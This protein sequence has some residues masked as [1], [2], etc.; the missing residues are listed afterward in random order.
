MCFVLLWGCATESH[1]S[2]AGEDA[3]SQADKQHREARITA[4]HELAKTF[5]VGKT[6]G[7]FYVIYK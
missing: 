2:A 6:K 5:D 3:N 4:M 7:T 1:L